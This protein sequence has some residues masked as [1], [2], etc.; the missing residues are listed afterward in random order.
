[1][2][3][4]GE[5]RLEGQTVLGWAKAPELPEPLWVELVHDGLSISATQ[6]NLQEPDNCG[7]FFLVPPAILQGEGQLVVKAC[8]GP[9]LPGPPID[10]MIEQPQGVIAGEFFIDRGHTISGWAFDPAEPEKKL[11]I[12]AWDKGAPVASALAAGHWIRPQEA[13]GHGFRL[14]L[15]FALADGKKHE[16]ILMDEKSRPIPGCPAFIR[17]IPE[18]LADWVTGKSSLSEAEKNGLGEILEGLEYRNPGVVTLSSLDYWAKAF[19]H[20]APEKKIKASFRFL[21]DSTASFPDIQNQKGITLREDKNNPEYIIVMRQG[22]KLHPHALALM[23]QSLIAE[24]A[25]IIYADSRG[26]DGAGIFKPAFDKYMFFG[27]DYLGPLV[28]SGRIIKKIALG[29]DDDYWTARLKLVMAADKILHLPRHLS[30][31]LPAQHSPARLQTLNKFLEDKDCV[32]IQ[33]GDFV[34][35]SYNVPER[36]LISL[37]IPTRDQPDLLKRCLDSLSLTAWPDYEVIVIDNDTV[38][39]D[40]LAIL[41]KYALRENFRIL[42]WPGLFN[43][44]AINNSAATVAAGELL[45]LMNNDT[46][47]IHP[48]WLNEMA[49]PLLASKGQVGAVGA[50]LLWPN[51]LVQHGGVIV[52]LHELAAHVGNEW[53]DDEPG[54]MGSNQLLRQFSSVTAAC[55]LTPRSIFLENGGFNERAFPVT[56]NDVD[57]CLRLRE[58]GKQILWTPHARIIHHESASRGKDE[59]P[60]AKARAFREMR[61]FRTRWGKYADPFYNPNLPLSIAAHPYMGLAFPPRARDC[62]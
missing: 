51:M 49:L 47:V 31:E 10:I 45:C 41:D 37:I 25:D 60:S 62:R 5:Y 20:P 24:K 12:T 61:N 35:L 19:P 26:L 22:E 17:A 15:P 44:A 6:A 50:K 27:G 38:N 55:L 28:V 14:Q 21:T 54:Y 16:I 11:R 34:K 58:A 32:A 46:E 53:L 2:K 39:P 1:M 57:Y 40:A 29:P 33:Q 4:S 52:G 13:E 59:S 9:I 7:F 56:F 3:I 48:E 42:K 43:Y 23:L 18:N 30:L 8:N 36:P